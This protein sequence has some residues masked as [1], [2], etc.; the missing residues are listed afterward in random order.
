MAS[1]AAR[2]GLR[3]G[4]SSLLGVPGRFRRVNPRNTA[5]PFRTSSQKPCSTRIFRSHLEM[6][7]VCAVSMLPYHTAT[8]SAILTSMLSVSSRRHA[9]TLEG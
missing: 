4:V 9:W 5:S 8:A 7:C 3:C 6:N 2:S 1:S